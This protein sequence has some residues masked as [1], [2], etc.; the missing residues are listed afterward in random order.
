[1]FRMQTS[2]SSWEG[3]E[4]EKGSGDYYKDHLRKYHNFTGIMCLNIYNFIINI[5]RG[6][7]ST[8]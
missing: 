8:R 5:N 1:M 2:S 4:Y 6:F 7:N 3:H